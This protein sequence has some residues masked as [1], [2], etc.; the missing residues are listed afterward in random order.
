MPAHTRPE[1]CDRRVLRRRIVAL[2]LAGVAAGSVVAS[3]AEEDP[4]NVQLVAGSR[5]LLD[6]PLGPYVADGQVDAERLE[7]VIADRLPRGA[8]SVRGRADVV[9]RFDAAGTLRRVLAV[10]AEG[11]TVEIVQRPVAASVRVPVVRQAQAN[12]CESA[13]LSVLLAGAGVRVDQSELQAALPRSAPLDP[14]GVGPQ[15]VWGD[16]EQGY[17][18][19]P[20]G[21]G[22]AGGFGVFEGPVRSVARSYGVALDRLSGAPASAVYDRLLQGRPVMVWI[23]LSDGPYGEWRSPSGRRVRVNFGEHTVVL[24][25]IQ[26]DGRLQVSNP[27]RGTD[28]VWAKADFERVWALLD[29][30]A[31]AP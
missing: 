4:G 14:I 16:P 12:T 17:V 27:L 24:Y 21:G 11:G 18:G 19:R 26:A 29:R 9:T 25:G 13:A 20:D 10:G 6:L 3:S 7:R 28:E 30:R 31:V 22:T 8:R 5:V 23:G 15:R 2:S 1:R